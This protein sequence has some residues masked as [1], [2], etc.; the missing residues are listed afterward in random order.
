VLAAF[1]FVVLA[2]LGAGSILT[3]P[4]LSAFGV[5]DTLALLG[6]G[7]AGLALVHAIRFIRLDRAMPAPGADVGLLR[8]LA[9]FAPLSLAVTELLATD[10][11]PHHFAPGVV[12]VREG[13][14]GDR[15]YVIVEG[16]ATVTVRG[17]PR[18]TLHA[19][20]CFGEIALLRDTPRTATITA[21]QP[22]HTLALGRQEFLTAITGNSISRAAADT[23][24]A[25]RLAADPAGDTGE[26]AR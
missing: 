25:R 16:T 26:T 10:L 13:E 1:E 9:M 15:F 22:L 17:V 20:D 19:G 5:R 4:L 12:V 8:N 11:E 7:L 24:A 21:G 14:P 2:G 3:P 6:G 18:P 23:L